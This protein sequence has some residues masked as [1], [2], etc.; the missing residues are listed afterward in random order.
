MHRT[1][2]PEHEL[3]R[4]ESRVL[5]AGELRLVDRPL[6]RISVAAV[7]HLAGRDLLRETRTVAAPSEPSPSNPDLGAPPVPQPALSTEPSTMQ[8]ARMPPNLADDFK[9]LAR[10]NERSAS[11]ELHR[12]M[13]FWLIVAGVA[14]HHD[15]EV[16]EAREPAILVGRLHDFRLAAIDDVRRAFEHAEPEQ[17]LASLAHEINY[18]LRPGARRHVGGVANLST[19]RRAAADGGTALK[20][21]ATAPTLTN[22]PHRPDAP[23]P[24]RAAIYT[25]VS[26]GRQAE[27][28]YSLPEQERPSIAHV[29]RLG[30]TH[31][32][33][34]R[35]AGVSGAKECRPRSTVCSATSTTSPRRSR[36]SAASLGRTGGAWAGAPRRAERT[37]GRARRGR[38]RRPMSLDR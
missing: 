37:S 14:A 31:V 9:A 28:G 8:A 33:T 4:P 27:E 21:E 22:L 15:A 18:C 17:V 23:G 38:A 1:C 19:A 6:Q 20:V 32:R 35:E 10:Q 7:E 3:L 34:Y 2:T 26:T 25:R 29:E 13:H 5:G 11:D 16:V 36:R 12:A 24:Q 30:W